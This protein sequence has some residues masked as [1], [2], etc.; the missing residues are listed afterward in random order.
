MEKKLAMWCMEHMKGYEYSLRSTHEFLDALGTVGPLP[1]EVMSIF[2]YES[3]FPML[4][5]EPA[6]LKLYRFMIKHLP[7]KFSKEIIRNLCH[8]QMLCHKSYFTF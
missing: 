3:L 1:Q 8:L 5:I 2:D 6:C 4:K 7:S